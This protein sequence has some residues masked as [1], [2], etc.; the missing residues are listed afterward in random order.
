[1]EIESITDKVSSSTSVGKLGQKTGAMAA[2]MVQKPVSKLAKEG[3]KFADTARLETGRKISE[4]PV[5]MKFRK[6]GKGIK[7][8]AKRMVGL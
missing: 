5:G 6:W 2:Q 3:L 1:M 7:A 4:S 8:G